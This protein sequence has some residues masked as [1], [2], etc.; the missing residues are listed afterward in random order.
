MVVG[1]VPE[2]AWHAIETIAKVNDAP[3]WKYGREFVL[4]TGFDGY[5]VSTPN[6]A[7][8]RLNPGIRG[9]PQPHNMA[10]AIAAC[11]AAGFIKKPNKVGHGVGK[12]T[13]PGRMQP[14]TY[15]GQKFLLDGAHNSD[16]A[17]NLVAGL[18]DEGRIVLLTGMLEGHVPGEFYEPL[19]TI[20]D[21]VHFSP[22]QFH[23]SRSP[24]DLDQESGFLFKRS[25]VHD[26]VEDAILGCLEAAPDLVLVTGSFYLVGEVGRIL[27]LG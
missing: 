5:R 24:R 20:V 13:I 27:G 4:S 18:R 10:V 7:Y 6:G 16:A 19:A 2:E 17:L 12:A 23:R 25:Y 21:E 22:I 9:A 14:T 15:K 3:V 8:E 1:D 11:D 26:S